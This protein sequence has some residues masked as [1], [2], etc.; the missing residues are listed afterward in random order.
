ME[1]DD[2]NRYDNGRADYREPAPD[3]YQPVGATGGDDI[4]ASDNPWRRNVTKAIHC[5]WKNGL[6]LRQQQTA[7]HRGAF[8]AVT[9]P[10]NLPDAG[11]RR[12]RVALTTNCR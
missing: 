2:W 9:Y 3:D 10:S 1:G 6:G 11:R 4:Q 5:F 8:V 12:R 7:F